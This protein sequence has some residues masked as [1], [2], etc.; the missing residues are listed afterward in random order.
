MQSATASAPQ[1]HA[2]APR[3][4]LLYKPDG[5]LSQFVLN[6]QLCHRGCCAPR[7]LSDLKSAASLPPGTMAIGRLDQDS[8]GLLLLTTD[9]RLFHVVLIAAVGAATGHPWLQPSDFLAC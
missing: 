7:L 4:A 1:Q 2:S 8:E 3:H 9:G 6:E 5:V